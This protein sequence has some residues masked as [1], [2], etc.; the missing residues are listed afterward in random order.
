M[1]DQY[2][3]VAVNDSWRWAKVDLFM[4]HAHHSWL[5]L[6]HSTI[7]LYDVQINWIN[8]GTL[9]KFKKHYTQIRIKRDGKIILSA[10]P[11]QDEYRNYAEHWHTCKLFI[12]QHH[13]IT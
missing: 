4:D 1:P 10:L 8:I 2:Y 12:Y 13:A 6:L 5:S 11:R 7:V 9:F 3:K